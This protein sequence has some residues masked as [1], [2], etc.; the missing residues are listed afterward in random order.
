MENFTETERRS[1]NC[2]YIGPILRKH[3]TREIERESNKTRS[4]MQ[5]PKAKGKSDLTQV[6]KKT[7]R[8]EKSKDGGG[9]SE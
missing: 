2:N 5:Q 8:K 9:E 1:L 7:K 3:D 6:Q 4:T